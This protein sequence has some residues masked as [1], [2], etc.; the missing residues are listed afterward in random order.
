MSVDD[1]VSAY[2]QDTVD[3]MALN[4]KVMKFLADNAVN[5]AGET[6]DETA[7]TGSETASEAAETAK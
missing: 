5:E 4:Y 1:I 6:A 3:T 7:E 2:G